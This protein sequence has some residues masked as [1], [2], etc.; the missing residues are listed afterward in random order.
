MAGNGIIYVLYW[1][2]IV[3]RVF[4]YKTEASLCGFFCGQKQLYLTS[5]E[6]LL[7]ISRLRI[8]ITVWISLGLGS[9]WYEAASI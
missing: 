7:L 9:F 6:L 4:E 8:L 5:A 1:A 2:L 3:F